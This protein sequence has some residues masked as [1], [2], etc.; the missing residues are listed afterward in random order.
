MQIT[1]IPCED[2]ALGMLFYLVVTSIL[3]FEFFF[4]GGIKDTQICSDFA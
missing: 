1:T 4:N 2:F 3:Y